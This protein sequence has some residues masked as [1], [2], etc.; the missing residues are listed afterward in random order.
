[1]QSGT[2]A[3]QTGDCRAG[4]RF[5][6]LI[7]LAFLLIPNKVTPFCLSSSASIATKSI[8]TPHKWLEQGVLPVR[9]STAGWKTEFFSLERAGGNPCLCSP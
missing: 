5:V 6:I 9:V 7:S 8:P 1:M 2:R 3:M 4:R